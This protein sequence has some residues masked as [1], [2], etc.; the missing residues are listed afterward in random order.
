MFCLDTIR[1][2]VHIRF[3]LMPSTVSRISV[4]CKYNDSYRNYLTITRILLFY[5]KDGTFFDCVLT[6]V[7]NVAGRAP[8]TTRESKESN[9][10]F[11]VG[12]NSDKM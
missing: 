11:E 3:H 2:C 10:H 7:G 9:L 4:G 8:T 1:I 5:F 6:L 12:W